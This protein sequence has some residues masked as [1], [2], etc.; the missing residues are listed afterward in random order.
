MMADVVAAVLK[1][2]TTIGLILYYW[3]EAIFLTFVPK[4]L[5]Y[6]DISKETVLITGGGSGIGR[7]LALRFAK[8]GTRVV[9]WDINREGC[10][11]TERQVRELG[12]QAYVY[13]CDVSDCN[14]INKRAAQVKQEVGSITILVNNAGIVTGKRFLDCSEKEIVKTFEVNALSHF[15]MCKAFIPDM[16]AKNHGHLVSIASLAGLGG[17]VGLTDYCASKFAAVGFDE[18]LRLEIKAEGYDGIK[19]TVVC[20]FFTNTGMFAGATPGIFGFLKPE[21]VADE[22]MSAVLTNQEMLIIPKLFYVMY[23]LKS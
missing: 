14:S 2:L 6:K 20:P 21:F 7:L 15:W 11:E 1:V 5:R 19:S 10:E 3:L 18:T 4:R 16:I 23:M 8:L 22:I 13:D 17:V 12:G 9:L